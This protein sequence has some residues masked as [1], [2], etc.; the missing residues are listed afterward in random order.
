M[1]YSLQKDKGD[2]TAEKKFQRESEGMAASW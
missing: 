2:K 1:K